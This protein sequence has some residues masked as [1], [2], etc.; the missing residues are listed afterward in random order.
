[1][2]EFIQLFLYD[3]ID[4]VY[5]FVDQDNNI[6]FIFPSLNFDFIFITLLVL[7]TIKFTFDFL[8]VLLSKG[9]KYGS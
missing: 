9:E 6:R 1:M 7:T 2:S 4:K 5:V 3:Y 8:Y